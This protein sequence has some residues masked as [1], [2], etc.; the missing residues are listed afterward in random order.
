[1]YNFHYNFIKKLY[2]DKASLLFTDTDSL[3]YEIECDDIYAD[4]QLHSEY[5]D[6]SDYPSTHP[7]HDDK[8]KKVLVDENPPKRYHC[9]PTKMY[10]PER[11]IVATPKVRSTE[12]SA[13]TPEVCFA[14]PPAT[15]TPEV[16]F[17]QPPATNTPKVCFAQPPATTTASQPSTAAPQPPTTAGSSLGRD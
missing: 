1:M 12:P 16:C 15:T 17:A 10:A 7:L 8:N 2:D 13:T 11:H 3:C 9:G 14:Q 6:T 5:F 4:M